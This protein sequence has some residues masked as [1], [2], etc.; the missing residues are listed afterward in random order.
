MLFYW[1]VM[2]DGIGLNNVVVLS[3]LFACVLLFFC[4]S[5]SRNLGSYRV[6]Y[7]S[8]EMG[9]YY[10]GFLCLVVGMFLKKCWIF[11]GFVEI[12]L[13]FYITSISI[14]NIY[15]YIYIYMYLYV[16]IYVYIYIYTYI[17]IYIYIYVV[18]YIHIYIY[19]YI[20][21]YTYIYQGFT[22]DCT[23]RVRLNDNLC[24]LLIRYKAILAK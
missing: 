15:M 12:G 9:A 2:T 24:G 23:G 7:F 21:I 14:S 11:S 10:V 20:Y 18:I 16:Y 8:V 4:C 3:A 22:W 13:Y 6:S 19:I 17:Y 5:C 1:I